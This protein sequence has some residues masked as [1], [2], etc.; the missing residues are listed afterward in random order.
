MMN[1]K[2]LI[3]WAVKGIGAEIDGLEKTINQGKQLLLQ[4][5]RGE[6]PKT[7]KTPYEIEQII[8]EKRAEIEKLSKMRFDLT[9]ELEV[10]MGG[11]D[12]ESNN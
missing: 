6:K 5:E 11:N 9:W 8:R 10:E 12:N 7:T 1:Q 3:A 2:D 4:F